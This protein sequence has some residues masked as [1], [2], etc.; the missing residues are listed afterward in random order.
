MT[1]KVDNIV[2]EPMKGKA[3][4]MEGK[5]IWDPFGRE[6]PPTDVSLCLIP[7]VHFSLSPCPPGRGNPVHLPFPSDLI[8]R[9]VQLGR[10]PQASSLVSPGSLPENAGKSDPSPW[11]PFISFLSRQ[12]PDYS[13]LKYGLFDFNCS[14]PGVIFHSLTTC[15]C[16]VLPSTSSHSHKCV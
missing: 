4:A 1:S 13:S 11:Y 6:L 15:P 3:E 16:T 10:L 5:L 2:S 14:T 7:A 12:N 8:Q 9:G